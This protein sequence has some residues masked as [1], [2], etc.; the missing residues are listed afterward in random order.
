VGFT[1]VHLPN[2]DQPTEPPYVLALIKLDGADT[3]LVYLLGDV[4]P[5]NVTHG[6]RVEPV[7]REERYG[8]MSDLKHF[9][10]LQR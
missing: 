10:P 4:D 5:D 8:Y 1:V 2:D 3:N 9:K 7:W 6:M